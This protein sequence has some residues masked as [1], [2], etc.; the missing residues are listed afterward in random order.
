MHKQEF[1]KTI[2]PLEKALEINP[3]SEMTKETIEFV[4]NHETAYKWKKIS[5]TDKSN[6]FQ[7]ITNNQ[8][9]IRNEMLEEFKA[10]R[11]SFEKSSERHDMLLIKTNISDFIQFFFKKPSKKQIEKLKMSL[12]GVL[13]GY[14]DDMRDFVSEEYKRT[15]EQYK[16]FMPKEW[17]KW[18]RTLIKLIPFILS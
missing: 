14:P 8:E 6:N 1:N 16:F 18:G 15:L 11:K 10:F 9:I 17:K 2:E 5:E 7:F 3:E 12:E 13:K 4:K